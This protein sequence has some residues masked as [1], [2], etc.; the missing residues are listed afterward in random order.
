MGWRLLLETGLGFHHYK[1]GVCS[2]NDY[3]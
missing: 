3:W 2:C 1:A